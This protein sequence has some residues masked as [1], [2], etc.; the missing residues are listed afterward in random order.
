MWLTSSMPDCSPKLW[1]PDRRVRR[2][3]PPRA[4]ARGRAATASQWRPRHE[5]ARNAATLPPTRVAARREVAPGRADQ[6]AGLH[7]AQHVAGLDRAARGSAWSPSTP[8]AASARTA[9]RRCSARTRAL[10]RGSSSRPPMLAISWRSRGA[11]G[12]PSSSLD[13]AARRRGDHGL[14]LGR[15]QVR[16]GHRVER[17]VALEQRRRRRRR[18]APRRRP[19][20]Q[21]AARR[22][23][24]G[25][26]TRSRRRTRICGAAAAEPMQNASS[27]PQRPSTSV[28]AT[29]RPGSSCVGGR[30]ERRARRGRP[31]RGCGRARLRDSS[32]ATPT[33]TRSQSPYS[34]SATTAGSRPRPARADHADRRAADHRRRRARG[35][36]AREHRRVEP[37]VGEHEHDLELRAARAGRRAL[38]RRCSAS[39]ARHARL[40]CDRLRHAPL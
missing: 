37:P 32:V 24:R 35:C 4:R 8:R 5:N 29:W 18:S 23:R 13:H 25:R 39:S 19:T 6:I 14:A 38:A 1:K 21:R 36:D 22:A 20:P 33:P 27:R 30:A 31:R 26:S 11:A 17:L 12:R 9:R 10:G 16:R 2:R 3:R 15:H 40:T 7:Q 34:P 28:I